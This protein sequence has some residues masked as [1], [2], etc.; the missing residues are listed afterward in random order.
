MVQEGKRLK[1]PTV[2]S[3]SGLQQSEWQEFRSR[4]KGQPETSCRLAA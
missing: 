3:K 1:Q 2:N 4:N